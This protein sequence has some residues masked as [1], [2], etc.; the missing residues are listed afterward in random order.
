MKPVLFLSFVFFIAIGCA[1]PG[2]SGTG[3]PSG[4]TPQHV[5]VQPA[6]FLERNDMFRVAVR[7]PG[8][9]PAQAD[10]D[11]A[12][13]DEANQDQ[14]ETE[15]LTIADPLEKF[16]RA[17]FTFN[18]RLYFWV[19]KPVAQGYNKVVPE[20]ARVSVRN[21]FDNIRFPIR[22]VNN[23][24]QA[25]FE[26]A[27]SELGRFTVNTVW[28]I[29]GLLEPSS[30]EDL[31]I[32]KYDADLGQTLG[33][34]GVGPGL[35]IIYP[36]LGPSSARDTVGLVGD[37]I[38]DPETWFINPWYAWLGTRAYEDVNAVSLRLGDYESLKE[39]A[40][41]PY[42]ALRDAFVQY[43]DKK[44]KRSKEPPKPGGVW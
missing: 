36:F 18:D 29:G 20:K 35:F 39:A 37:T 34:Y 4:T 6:L 26:G 21:F 13:G 7:D 38:L 11:Q 44:I 41:D 9:R 32:P 5:I 19:L 27:A 14:S 31:N 3:P 17:M 25:N 33:I 23:L 15:D 8:T 42:L 40:I 28:G 10:T 30:K 16:N 43:R 12:P 1:H 2:G 22:F 24:L